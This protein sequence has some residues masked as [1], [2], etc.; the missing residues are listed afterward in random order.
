MSGDLPA[1]V[2]PA[3]SLI[4]GALA[5]Y[6]GAKNA[7]QE[8]LARLEANHENTRSDITEIRARVDDAH[9]RINRIIENHGPK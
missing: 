8:R 9:A 3:I 7:M 6:Y 2:F 4:V 5:A 1:W